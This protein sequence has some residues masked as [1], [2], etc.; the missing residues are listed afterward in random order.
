MEQQP[1]DTDHEA[2]EELSKL[3]QHLE[4][5]ATRRSSETSIE[6]NQDEPSTPQNTT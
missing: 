1:T 3:E 5:T 4:M 2:I 6:S